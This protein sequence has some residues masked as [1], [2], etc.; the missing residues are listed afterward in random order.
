MNPAA[1]P[2]NYSDLVPGGAHSNSRL[3]GGRPLVASSA[4]GSR[5]I[6]R[7][8]NEFVDYI[9]GNGSVVLGHAAP[10]VVAA[11][12]DCARRGLTTGFESTFAMKAAELLCS[13]IPEPGMV[14]FTTTGTEAV[15]H[16]LDIARA[17]TGRRRFAK[18]EGSY[19]GWA[20]P[21]NVSTWP[22]PAEWGPADHPNPVPGAAG[23][24]ESSRE[25]VIFPFN[26]LDHTEKLLTEWESDLAAVLI[27]PIL[28]DV[29]YVPAEREFLV[30]LR[31]LTRRIG[32]LLIFDETLTGFRVARGGARELYG[33]N[34]D[35]TIYGK[36]IANGY[37]LAAVEGRPRLLELTN[38]L[39][40]GKVGFVGT[41]NGHA[42]SVAAA[43]A[44]LTTLQ[45]DDTLR[46]IG[47]LT[48]ELEAGV[49]EVAARSA[50]PVRFAGAGGHFQIYFTDQPVRDYRSAAASDADAY[51]VFVRECD[52]AGIL[53]PD[54]QLGHA[55]LSASHSS[56]DIARLL[57]ALE[58]A[59]R[60]PLE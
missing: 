9:M 59:T 29:G 31:E 56:S 46:R 20:S 49:G 12:S 54:N 42:V 4:V 30:G 27:E 35:L 23:V 37:P 10:Q 34:P 19:H 50:V 58:Q 13:L 40:G 33:V 32:C 28:I 47:E 2:V 45:D 41:H 16:S 52:R 22:T 48:R 18:A 44:S 3:R 60:R 1:A 43:V 51:Q 7:D 11:V 38:P 36:A 24:A 6:D 8:G 53:Y 14:R 55:A 39:K 21:L 26:D 57:V 25:V 5:V 17:A 15:L